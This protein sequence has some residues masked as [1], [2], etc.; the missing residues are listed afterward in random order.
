MP[1]TDDIAGATLNN[2][3]K[4]ALPVGT[5]LRSYEVLSTLGQGGFG[6]T[7]RARDTTL[8]REVAIK[9]YLP[10]ALALR[11]GPTH[12]SPRST[13]HAADYVWGR[14]RFLDEARTLARFSD[15]PSVVHVHDFLEANGTAYMVMALVEGET[16]ERRLRAGPVT[17]AEISHFLS[18][19]LDG[20]A[21]LHEAGFLHRDIKPANII[22][23]KGGTP[24]LIDFGAARAAMAGHTKTLTAVFTPGYA[25]IEQFTSASQGPATD[26]YAL[27]ATLCH[28][29]VGRPPPSAMD[30]MLDDGYEP[31]V[32][33]K[34]AGFA[35]TMLA[36]IDA[37]LA[38]RT[39]DR[40]QSVAAWRS[41]L[42]DGAS[43]ETEIT[44]VVRRSREKVV[45]VRWLRRRRRVVLVLIALVIAAGG[46]FG[47]RHYRNKAAAVPPAKVAG[48]PAAAAAQ[49][50]ADLKQFEQWCNNPTNDEQR[51]QGCT[52]LIDNGSASVEAYYNR[53]F[54]YNNKGQFDKAIADFDEALKLKPDLALAYNNRGFSYNAK[55]DFDRAESDLERAIKLDPTSA[56]AHNNLGLAFTNKGQYDRAIAT[57]NEAIRLKPRLPP[58]L[59]NRGFAFYSKG[60]Y[61]RAIE[62]FD[63]ALR[64]W[65]DYVLAHYYRG[66]SLSAKG[67]YKDAISDFDATVRLKPDYVPGYYSR[68]LAHA[69]AHEYDAAIADFDQALRLKPDLQE[70]VMARADAR[71]AKG[72]LA[73]GALAPPP[74]AL[75]LL[76]RRV[77]RDRR[78][79]RHGNRR[80]LGSGRRRRG[81]DRLRRRSDDRFRR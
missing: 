30:R 61:D 18:P 60:E 47:D 57:F 71:R 50:G 28:A 27:A 34:P 67:D 3:L 23:G 68:G 20:L 70:A 40:P 25:P 4:G 13:D 65:P 64:L 77:G 2:E 9:E 14:E 43:I 1:A 24:T 66:L 32:R 55:G 72:M 17:A 8:D 44:R 19:L 54:A 80:G 33:R 7:Y 63:Q 12:V 10:S 53:G 48:Q 39:A 52:G 26:I 46:Y 59:S 11:D 49:A 38:L 5:R 37:G 21:S 15:V 51:I 78:D 74:A 29:I 79:D 36:A 56:E 16:L 58:S 73:G 45:S 75:G 42:L 62:D 81:G 69:A 31:L 35:P 22:L 41:M 76:R 6:I